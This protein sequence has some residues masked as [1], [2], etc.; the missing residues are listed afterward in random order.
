MTCQILYSAA[1]VEGY[2][3]TFV[4]M[5]GIWA[6]SIHQVC[7]L[8]NGH[9]KGAL[10]GFLSH[11]ALDFTVCDHLFFTVLLMETKSTSVSMPPGDDLVDEKKPTSLLIAQFFLFPLIIIAICIGIFLLFGYLTYEQKTPGDY[12]RDVQTG[13]GTQRWQ[14][15]YELSNMISRDQAKVAGTDF[16]RDVIAVY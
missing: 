1:P 7:R 5:D 2:G 16:A 14:A 4:E 11:G 9:Q 13:S 10:V 15:A 3:A 6:R 12:L 8:G